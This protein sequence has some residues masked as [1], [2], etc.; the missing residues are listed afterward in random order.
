METRLALVLGAGAR[1]EDVAI[2]SASGSTRFKEL[3]PEIILC[4]HSMISAH[5]LV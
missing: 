4:S 1:R 3:P 5:E 2:E